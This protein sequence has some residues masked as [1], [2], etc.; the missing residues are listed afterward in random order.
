MR[1]LISVSLSGAIVTVVLLVMKP[2]TRKHLSQRWQYYVWLLVVLRLLLPLAP[3]VTVPSGTLP[4]VLT[5]SAPSVATSV[6]TTTTPVDT[7]PG[8]SLPTGEP[9]TST[10]TSP[11]T[12]PVTA[13][14]RTTW[15]ASTLLLLIWAIGALAVMI[16]NIAGYTRFKRTVQRTM[17]RVTDAHFLAILEKCRQEV[18]V[19]ATPRLYT[20]ASVA[21]PIL[22]GILHPAIVLPDRQLTDNDLRYAL[23]HELTH[24]RRQ[25]GLLKWIAAIA[26]SIH[27]FNPLAYVMQ[28]ELNHSCE[29]SCDETVTR[30]FST[31]DRR[32]YGSMLLAVASMTGAPS[33]AM[34]SAMVEDKRNLKERLGVIMSSNKQTKRTIAV[35]A[36]TVLL[37]AGI[38]FVAG[39]NFTTNQATLGTVNSTF[40]DVNGLLAAPARVVTSYPTE[41]LHLGDDSYAGTP[42]FLDGTLY[43]FSY[44]GSDQWTTAWDQATGKKLWSVLTNADTTISPN[45]TFTT[46]G[47][48]LFF[49]RQETFTSQ[50]M[51]DSI[52]PCVVYLDK[53]TGATPQDRDI[54]L[55]IVGQLHTTVLSN[56]A[57]HVNQQDH[58]PDKMYLLCD[59]EEKNPSAPS[60]PMIDSPT[61]RGV[62]IR[63]RDIATAAMLD[64]I[65]M[66][67]LPLYPGARGQLLCDGET[68]YACIPASATSSTLVA[69]N[70]DTNKMLWKEQLSGEAT[71]LIK[72]G[73]TLAVLLSNSK[74]E[75]S[76]D[77]WK[78]PARSSDKATRLWTRQV[79]TN[80]AHF[81]IDGA[82][83]YLQGGNGALV[84]LDLATGAEAWRHQFASYKTPITDGPDMGKSHD[85]YPDMTLT[86]TRDV[87]YVNDG[88]GLVT[89]LEPATGKELWNK[90][91]S[92]VVW[93][94]TYV[95]NTFVLQPINKGI[96]VVM[97]DGTISIWQ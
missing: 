75:R 89:A 2:L 10:E 45:A 37:I 69:F 82:H 44:R 1:T 81:A 77:V 96:A 13:N 87:L 57:L 3:T 55:E 95:D 52:E 29:L 64:S 48:Y 47:K 27:W 93:H 26:A 54:P 66:T 21:S 86:T 71:A 73:D 17:V 18:H 38:A 11:Q 23:L 43:T 20:S 76:I 72:Q 39:C 83:V 5:R 49:I 35:S 31:D 60:N 94:Q 85:L 6:P 80:P 46:D 62:E 88:G 42:Q 65:N 19:R 67:G 41:N 28:Y 61:G 78:I 79:E 15:P 12:L 56:F 40:V 34:F 30:Q 50:G 92:Q 97:S 59:E 33:P 36:I 84:A 90:R 9:A 58:T 8:T 16:W 14:G 68:L 70:L 32:G 53:A 7:V 25:D 74:Q 51:P 63:V 22:L 24:A 4:S 91:I